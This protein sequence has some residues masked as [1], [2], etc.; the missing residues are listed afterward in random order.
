M[1]PSYPEN[2]PGDWYV[3]KDCCIICAVP[4][5]VAPRL[6]DWAVVEQTGEPTHCFVAR[7]P[8]G[9]AEE[10]QMVEAAWGAEVECIRYKGIEER[11]RAKL[12]ARGAGSAIDD[13]NHR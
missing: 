13:P 3:E 2:V 10:A 4:V 5:T 9:A 12:R 8:R 7:Q 6:F 11:V 1:R